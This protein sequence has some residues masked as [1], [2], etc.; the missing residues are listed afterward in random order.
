[1]KNRGPAERALL[2]AFVVA[3]SLG[4]VAHAGLGYLPLVGPPPLRMLA[5]KNPEA[6][7]GSL[8]LTAD[9]NLTTTLAAA[10]AN[11][12]MP[13]NAVVLF[14]QTNA[15]EDVSPIAA[16][17]GNGSVDPFGPSVFALAAPD[18]LAITPQMLA[19]YF[20]PVA[21]STNTAAEVVVPFPVM[22]MPP[23]AK[24]RPSSHAEYIVK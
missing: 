11:T 16:G 6:D 5:S 14:G 2:R 20:N 21:R 4:A 22:F 7:A 1:M 9:T 13:T 8:N 10:E 17:A 15:T 24:A 19:A 18:L 23:T 3:V 12:W